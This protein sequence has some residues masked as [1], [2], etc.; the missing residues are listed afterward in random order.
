M[1]KSVA[2][3]L[4][5]W[6]SWGAGIFP[7]S[8]YAQDAVT[9]ATKAANVFS[10]KALSLDGKKVLL[11]AYKGKA[12]LIVNTASRCGFTPQYRSLETL[13]EKYKDRGFEVLAF[14]ANN[15]RGQEP[16]SNEEIRDFCF[17]LFSKISVAGS[18]IHPLY[19]YLTTHSGFNGPITWNFNKFLVDQEG[20]V[21]NR[22]DSSVDPLDPSL[23][24]A[25]EALLSE[26]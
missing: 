25:L 10:Y 14:P 22:F 5:L 16:G 11:S 12:L 6:L 7:G 1:K 13:Y 2:V 20:K 8:I 9:H 3:A 26:K 15:F 19:A 4:S 24:S 18:D 21:V 23:T 17:P